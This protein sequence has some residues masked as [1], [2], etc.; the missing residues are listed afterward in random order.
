M[1]GSSSPTLHLFTVIPGNPSSRYKEDKQ[2]GVRLFKIPIHP[3]GTRFCSFHSITSSTFSMKP[4]KI[5][6]FDVEWRTLHLKS[7]K[8]PQPLLKQAGGASGRVLVGISRGGRLSTYTAYFGED[9]GCSPKKSTKWPRFCFLVDFPR[10][11]I[12][13]SVVFWVIANAFLLTRPMCCQR[14]DGV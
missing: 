3:R 14:L 2:C 5:S 9:F 8:L 1:S 7:Q 10:W 4:P 6:P 12:P 11:F 13:Q